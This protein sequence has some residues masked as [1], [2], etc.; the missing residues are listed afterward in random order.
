[1]PTNDYGVLFPTSVVGSMPRPDFVRDLIADDSPIS[2]E[3]YDRRMEAAVRYSEQVLPMIA[4][5]LE[6]IENAYRVGD[7]SMVDLRLSQRE[8]LE[9]QRT[10]LDVLEEHY[11]WRAELEGL[12]G[13]SLDA[14]PI[15]EE[16][17]EP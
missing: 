4:R 3:D 7:I 11:R 1:M 9:T 16:E 5:N 10:A 15:E 12:I 2:D 6:V 13:R 8:L 14:G 17:M